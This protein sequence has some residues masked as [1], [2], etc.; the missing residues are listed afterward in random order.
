MTRARGKEVQQPHLETE[1]GRYN[2]RYPRG[3]KKIRGLRWSRAAI[4]RLSFVFRGFVKA[5]LSLS[6]AF[7]LYVITVG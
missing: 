1:G 2:F 5:R 3:R 6:R 4:N 7:N